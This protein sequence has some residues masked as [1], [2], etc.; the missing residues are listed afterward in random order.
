MPTY[1][2]KYYAGPYSGTRTVKAPDEYEAIIKV[3]AMIR[4]ECT[5]SMYSDGYE[6]IP[7]DDEE[8]NNY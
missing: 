6:I 2:V 4:R 1:K 8:N 5:L 3:K 7:N